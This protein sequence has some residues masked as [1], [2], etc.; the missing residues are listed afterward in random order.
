MVDV[1]CDVAAR[2]A[3]DRPLRVYAEEVFPVAPVDYFIRDAW[4][5]VFDDS[6]TFGYGFQRKQSKTRGSA[7]YFVF[8]FPVI[9][10]QCS[11]FPLNKNSPQMNADKRG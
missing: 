1:A 2:T 3:I 6:F 4:P 5:R 7:P 8:A 9:F 11:K 10:T